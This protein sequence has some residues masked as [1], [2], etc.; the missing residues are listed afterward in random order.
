MKEIVYGRIVSFKIRKMATMKQTR[1]AIPII[2][3]IM[4]SSGC[5]RG[6]VSVLIS[7]L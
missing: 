6:F 7:L 4:L 5:D 2:S 1:R 3:F